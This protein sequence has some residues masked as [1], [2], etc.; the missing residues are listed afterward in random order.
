MVW[1]SFLGGRFFAD[2]GLYCLMDSI[3][4]RNLCW[5]SGIEAFGTN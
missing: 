3:L 2:G 4:V 5:I 1:L